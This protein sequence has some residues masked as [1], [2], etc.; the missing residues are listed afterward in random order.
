[1]DFE[2]IEILFV[3]VSGYIVP[4]GW[5]VFLVASSVS[6]V[7][8]IP[9][10]K[11]LT[12]DGSG[13][14]RELREGGYGL[15]LLAGIA[16]SLI[17]VIVACLVWRGSE[18]GGEALFAVSLGG[19]VYGIGLFAIVS[20][21]VT[22]GS[23]VRRLM[24]SPEDYP[25]IVEDPPE[26]PVPSHPLSDRQRRDNARALCERLYWQYASDLGEKFTR[27]DFAEYVKR[28][29]SDDDPPELVEARAADFQSF[30][31]DRV[32]EAEP[33]AKPVTV[34]EVE[35]W[36]QQEKQRVVRLDTDERTRDRL[37]RT[38][39]RRYHQL[40]E[41]MYDGAGP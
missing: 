34:E 24:F 18:A 35:A 4:T 28:Y 37:L 30:L 9:A 10:L 19:L 1:M 32:D 33:E 13:A 22:V 20:F 8:G 17:W 5:P 25:G 3:Q 7:I 2:Q 16:A 26:T 36:Y 39:H 29:L 40:L 12:D 6:G 14:S 21:C 38:L 31:Q 41:D 27:E 23:I 15:C 11:H